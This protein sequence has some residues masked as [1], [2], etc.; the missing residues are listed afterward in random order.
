MG[1]L[2][3]VANRVE[4]WKKLDELLRYTVDYTGYPNRIQS[5]MWF[6]DVSVHYTDKHTVYL[7]RVPNRV[8]D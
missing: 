7:N 1:Y 5:R 4:I 2:N 6:C 3:H 8:F